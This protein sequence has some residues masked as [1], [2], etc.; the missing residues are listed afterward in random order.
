MKGHYFSKKF[1]ES[2][3]NGVHIG[4]GIASF[5]NIR[6]NVHCFVVDGILIDTGA[7]SLAKEFRPYIERQDF[8]Q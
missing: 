1:E 5:Q 8:D 2:V 6:L 3:K 7:Q 4:N